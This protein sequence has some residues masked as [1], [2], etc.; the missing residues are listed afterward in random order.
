MVHC[1]ITFGI[2]YLVLAHRTSGSQLRCSPTDLASSSESPFNL[3][4]DSD[5]DSQI[6]CERPHCRRILLELTTH[7]DDIGL[8]LHPSDNAS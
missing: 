7:E 1:C 3:V 2:Y 8:T 4:R 5:S 6:L